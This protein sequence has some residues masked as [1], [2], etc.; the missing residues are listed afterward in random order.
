MTEV[1]PPLSAVEPVFETPNVWECSK[2]SHRA[3]MY[4]V[5]GKFSSGIPADRALSTS[6]QQ[7][8]RL[9]IRRLSELSPSYFP[10]TA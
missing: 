5:S 2:E 7:R 10:D 4:F 1:L 9:L 6:D 8:G 3:P